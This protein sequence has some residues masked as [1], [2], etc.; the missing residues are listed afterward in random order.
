MKAAGIILPTFAETYPRLQFS[1]DLSIRHG[2]YKG[3][4]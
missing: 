4:R 3:Q 1:E 2:K